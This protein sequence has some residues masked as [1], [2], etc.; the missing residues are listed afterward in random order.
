[1]STA[2]KDS[3]QG[4]RV[5]DAQPKLQVPWRVHMCVWAFMIALSVSP[6][7][8]L[9]EMRESIGR[10]DWVDALIA[11]VLIQGALWVVQQR[12][13][14]EDLSYWEGLLVAAASTAMRSSLISLLLAF[15]VLLM[16]VAASFLFAALHDPNSPLHHAALCFGKLIVGI[17]KRR[18]Y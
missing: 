11:V 17:H 16:T 9:L 15:P 14:S 4:G 2:D 8:C 6:V 18:L 10:Q 3:Q 1:M 13:S 7:L 12:C 5:K